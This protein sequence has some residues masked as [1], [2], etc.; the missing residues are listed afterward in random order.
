V[1]LSAEDRKAVGDAWGRLAGVAVD[2]CKSH[3][4]CHCAPADASIVAKRTEREAHRFSVD[5]AK[6]APS[7][8]GEKYETRVAFPATTATISLAVSQMHLLD[9][10][11]PM[12]TVAVG[13]GPNP[14]QVQA[15][16]YGSSVTVA[17]E[18]VTPPGLYVGR[19]GA[20]TGGPP[21]VPV[22]IFIDGLD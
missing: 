15:S 22:V 19:V 14:D 16:A 2:A 20:A 3:H 12:S 18:A 21:E 17:V 8:G 10:G 4:E 13:A 6:C 7:G 9:A 1:T 5:K 11:K